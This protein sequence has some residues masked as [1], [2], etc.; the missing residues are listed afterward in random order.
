MRWVIFRV[1]VVARGDTLLDVLLGELDADTATGALERAKVRWRGEL[2]AQSR[3]S[4]E[5]ETDEARARG[6]EPRWVACDPPPY[7]ERP[8]PPPRP[9][10]KR[11]RKKAP[12]VALAKPVTLRT[13]KTVLEV[14]LSRKEKRDRWIARA[15]EVRR[16]Q[17]G[18]GD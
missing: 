10:P 7:T 16:Q 18:G 6:V 11:D 15:Q 17:T 4:F 2:R 14:A 8:A 9:R 13:P 12:T 5:L 3:I 1:G